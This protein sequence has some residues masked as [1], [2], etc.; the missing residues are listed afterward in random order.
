MSRIRKLGNEREVDAIFRGF[1]TAQG[2]PHQAYAVIAGSGS[3]AATLHYDANNEP[4]AGRQVI[5]VDAGVEWNC[6][7]SDITRTFPLSGTFTPEA[8][9]IHSIVM[10]MQNECI[11]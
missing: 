9:A 3:N 10:R 4:F 1:C 5:C 7:A 8:A 6:Y 11:Q 2:A